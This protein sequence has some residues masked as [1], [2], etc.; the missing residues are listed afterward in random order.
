ME[1]RPRES[2]YESILRWDLY[3][4]R[5]AVVLA[6]WVLLFWTWSSLARYR[7]MCLGS[8]Y[9]LSFSLIVRSN[10]LSR[11]YCGDVSVGA[12]LGLRKKWLGDSSALSYF[13]LSD[14]IM[15]VSKASMSLLAVLNL[16]TFWFL[17]LAFFKA[18]TGSFSSA[19]FNLLLFILLS[20]STKLVDDE[21]FISLLSF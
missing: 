6:E 3:F 1:G 10:G 21:L 20:K 15:N 16:A 8:I 4:V 14:D 13:L 5:R 11:F 2:T 9:E 7:K 12:S 17:L 19:P 18:A